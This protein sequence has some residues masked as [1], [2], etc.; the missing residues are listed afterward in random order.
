M[1]KDN[2]QNNKQRLVRVALPKKGRL[3]DDFRL[4]SEQAG[5]AVSKKD[6][7]HDYGSAYDGR[8]EIEPFEAV[9]Q[10][11]ADAL[12]NMDDGDIDLAIVGLDRFI[13]AS[14]AAR[15]ENRDFNIEVVDRFNLSVCALYIAAP[16]D[17]P[18]RTP[19]DLSGKSVATS[20]PE[21]LKA[22]LK[23]NN[24]SNVSIKAREGG[25]EDYVRM[26]K[27]DAIMD[28]VDT[29]GTLEACGLKACIKLYGSSAVMVRRTGPWQAD[30]LKTAE[31]ICARYKEAAAAKPQKQSAVLYA[32]APETSQPFPGV[33]Y[34]N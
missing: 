33:A 4:V 23:E 7:R 8:G 3:K 12:E 15:N 31:Q 22:W 19:Q 34:A 25:I 29:G 2:Q 1:N 9:S 32:I 11:P 20:Y 24:V 26:G 21:T 10:R 14:S 5:F 13:E 27:A 30:M 16:A 18:I 28:V 17:M 6:K